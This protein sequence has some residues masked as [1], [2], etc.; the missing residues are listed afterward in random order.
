MVQIVTVF[1]YP[2]GVILDLD[3]MTGVAT[4]HFNI[5]FA[6]VARCIIILEVTTER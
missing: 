3:L 6:F 4:D 1:Q 2:K 5:T